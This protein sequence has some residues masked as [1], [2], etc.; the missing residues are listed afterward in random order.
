MRDKVGRIYETRI[1]GATEKS[2]KQV[3]GNLRRVERQMEQ[4]DRNVTRS[5]RGS[6]PMT[7]AEQEALDAQQ[8]LEFRDLPPE[9]QQKITEELSD[10]WGQIPKHLR[11][12]AKDVR[13]WKAEHGH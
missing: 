10:M 5:R 3:I 1:A 12:K 6:L 8:H 2:F 11:E 9:Q 4:V 7:P 13:K